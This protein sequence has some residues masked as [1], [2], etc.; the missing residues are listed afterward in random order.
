MKLS[1]DFE[2]HGLHEHAI[3]IS[4]HQTRITK[5]LLLSGSD[6]VHRHR[7]DLLYHQVLGALRAQLRKEGFGRFIH[8][9]EIGVHQGA[10]HNA[11][12]SLSRG[13]VYGLDH[14][15]R[16]ETL[17][18]RVNFIR[19]EQGD[20]NALL[21]LL[22][23]PPFD[24]IIDDGSHEMR[25]QKQT[26]EILWPA[27]RVGGWYV[28]EDLHTSD[29]VQRS[30]EHARRYNP[31]DESETALDYFLRLARETACRRG[32]FDPESG[33]KTLLPSMQFTFYSDAVAIRKLHDGKERLWP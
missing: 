26:F 25:H 27:V 23:R 22:R 8:I 1:K 9:L 3:A 12:A 5:A 13:P 21:E 15:E 11:W 14:G 4:K 20:T 19:G 7:F 18:P 17:N 6:K 10:S 29:L 30:P 33:V 28:C 24:L 16:P 2:G 32:E 31:T